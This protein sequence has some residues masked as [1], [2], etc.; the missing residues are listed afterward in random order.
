MK[1]ENQKIE[2]DADRPT[3]E[4]PRITVMNEEEILKSFQVTQAGITWWTM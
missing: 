4:A 3:Y 1:T 2:R